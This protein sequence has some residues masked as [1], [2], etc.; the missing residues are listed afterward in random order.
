MIRVDFRALRN[1]LTHL[2]SHRSALDAPVPAKY[3]CPV[4]NA[5]SFVFFL[6][7]QHPPMVIGLP[8]VSWFGI[9]TSAGSDAYQKYGVFESS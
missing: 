1:T 7:F 9:S 3:I 4:P 6:V 2:A 5:K 8:I